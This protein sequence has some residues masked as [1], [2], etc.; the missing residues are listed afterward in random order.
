M[1][2]VR[3]CKRWLNRQLDRLHDFRHARWLVRRRR[4]SEPLERGVAESRFAKGPLPRL[5]VFTLCRNERDMIP[6]FVSHY[7]RWAE[8]IVVYDNESTDDSVAILRAASPKV[9]V[10]TFSTGGKCDDLARTRLRNAMWK[11]AKGKA[12]LAIVCDM[13]EFLYHPKMEDFLRA[14]KASGS[15]V[16]APVGAQMVSETFPEWSPGA[17]LTELVRTGFVPRLGTKQYRQRSKW[18]LLDPNAI[19]EMNWGPGLH[20]SS[21]KGNVRLWVSETALL[22]HYDFIGRSRLFEKMRRNRDRLTE[23][24]LRKGLS[25]HYLISEEKRLQWFENLLKRSTTLVG[26]SD[27]LSRE[28]CDRQ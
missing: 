20:T 27:E 12:D 1:K 8:K 7:E 4:E 15:T 23:E 11:E 17:Q 22:L 18:C 6:W 14:F 9:E 10:R 19:D 24:A 5:F 28:A 21:P 25:R 3:N 2:S 13:D 26:A 16:L